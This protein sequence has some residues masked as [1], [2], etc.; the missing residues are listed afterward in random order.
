MREVTAAL[1]LALCAAALACSRAQDRPADGAGAGQAQPSGTSGSNL[2]AAVSPFPAGL[3]GV[4]AFESDREG[5]PKIYTL[6][7]GT[8]R[9]ARLTHGPLWRDEKPAWSP[10]GRQI[11]FTSTRAGSY[12]IYVMNADGSAIRRLTNHVAPEQDPS[13][14]ADGRSVIFTAE[15]DGRGELYRV[16][17][18]SLKVDRVTTGFDRAI[19]PAVSPDGR[20]VAYAGQTI[21]YFQIHTAPLGAAG[22]EGVQLTSGEPACRP[23]WSPDGRQV[24]FVLG[25]GPSRLGVLDVATRQARTLFTHP[26]WLY[27]PDFSPDGSTVAFSISP[28]HHAGEDWDLAIVSTAAPDSTFQRLT[29]GPGNDRLPDWKPSTR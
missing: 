18:D 5:R 8:G 25:D 10:D 23:A 12:D 11:A 20:Q 14:A 3:G 9:V 17:I 24:A 19:M 27:Y 21:R 6:D 13:W 28:E 16:W 2:P 7:L 29:A 4:L 26:H 22:D 1:S 15:R